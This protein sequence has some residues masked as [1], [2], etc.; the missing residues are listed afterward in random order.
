MEKTLLFLFVILL[1]SIISAQEIEIDYPEKVQTNEEFS[2][3]IELTDFADQVHD[4]KI[5]ISCSGK[6]VSRIL[7]NGQWKSTFYYVNDAIKTKET[8]KLKI[9]EDCNSADIQI[10][11]RDSSE[12]TKIFDQYK[13]KSSTK[14]E[15]EEQKEESPSTT[16]QTTISPNIETNSLEES[17]NSE[18]EEINLIQLSQKT[19]KIEENIEK[20][21][22]SYATYGFIFF[23]VLLG[24]LFILKFKKGKYKNEFN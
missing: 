9:I 22:N 17:T 11:I 1:L 23:C 24:F 19:I 16:T 7:N 8:F 5:D 10:K 18:P 12:K 14:K 13:I 2:M 15:Q 4:A 3:Q 20:S 6:R 21:G